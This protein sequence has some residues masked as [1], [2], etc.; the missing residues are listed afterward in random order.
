MD[1]LPLL[2][3]L[4]QLILPLK[5]E[6]NEMR[7]NNVNEDEKKD[8]HPNENIPMSFARLA[9]QFPLRFAQPTTAE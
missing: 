6:A 7:N 4:I 5:A 1:N 3:P 9:F 2:G 8:L